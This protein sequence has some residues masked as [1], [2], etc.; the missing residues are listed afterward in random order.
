M[1]TE[2]KNND[3]KRVNIEEIPE[4]I[5]GEYNKASFISNSLHK[6][7]QDTDDQTSGDKTQEIDKNKIQLLSRTRVEITDN[8]SQKNMNIILMPNKYQTESISSIDF[9]DDMNKCKIKVENKGS[10]KNLYESKY[11]NFNR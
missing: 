3:T 4:E 2:Y 6:K 11:F 8:Y 10:N 7:A 5:E 1:S 9:R